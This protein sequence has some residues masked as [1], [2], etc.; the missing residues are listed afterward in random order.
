[1]NDYYLSLLFPRE[2]LMEPR[3]QVKSF[4]FL[5]FFFSCFFLSSF[6]IQITVSET[7]VGCTNHF[8]NHFTKERFFLLDKPKL[9][10]SNEW[11]SSLLVL[12]VKV[13]WTIVMYT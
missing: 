9:Y 12:K 10:N 6:L 7:L 13:N 11:Q 1:M 2:L 5:F 3:W 8:T 4:F